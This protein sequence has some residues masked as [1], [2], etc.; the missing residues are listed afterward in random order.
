MSTYWFSPYNPPWDNLQLRVCD[1]FLTFNCMQAMTTHL[2]KYDDGDTM[3]ELCGGE[4]RTTRVL[5]RYH[6]KKLTTGPNFD[7]VADI[8]L[9]EPG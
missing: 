7:L 6:N 5:V 2:L 4:V 3:C 1:L 9:T 8:D